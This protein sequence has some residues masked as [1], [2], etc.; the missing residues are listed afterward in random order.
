MAK[1]ESLE[2]SNLD[3]SYRGV[4]FLGLTERLRSIFNL[5]KISLNI[6]IYFRITVVFFKKLPL[7]TVDFFRNLPKNLKKEGSKIKISGTR[8]ELKNIWP[9]I[10]IGI[11]FGA[12]ISSSVFAR[13]M[14]FHNP[15]YVGETIEPNEYADL[16]VSTDPYT[17]FINEKEN[18]MIIELAKAETVVSSDENYILAPAEIATQKSPKSSSE[19]STRVGYITYQVLGGETMSHIGAKFNVSSLSVSWANTDVKNPDILQPGTN[20]SIPPRD[21]ISVVVEKGQSLDSLV[22]KYSGNFDGTLAAN[23]ITN[24]ETIFS[25]QKILITDGRPPKTPAPTPQLAKKSTGSVRGAQSSATG[26]TV[27]SGTF[28]WPTSGSICQ[29][30]RRGHPAIDICAGGSSPPIVASDGGVVTQAAYG[31]NYGYGNTVLIDHGNGFQTRYAHM[32]VLNVSNGQRVS[33][34][35]QLGIMGTTGNSTGIHL[36][37]E[38]HMGPA[39]L[40][41]LAYLR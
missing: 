7:M 2:N 35:Q 38:I 21:G 3:Q 6:Q 11:L 36:H 12:V 20:L 32:R 33:Q 5:K 9:H 30:F 29:G 40:N 25:G 1:K 24:P 13:D 18:D 16:A 37:F 8:F 22:K 31:W 26:P 17:P 19:P 10:G 41:P 14:G 28:K 27:P 39:R 34:G 15:Q 4:A 23:G